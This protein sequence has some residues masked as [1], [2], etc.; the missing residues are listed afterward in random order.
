MREDDLIDL[1]AASFETKGPPQGNQF[2]ADLTEYDG[3]R[4]LTDC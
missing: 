2:D 1:G 4:Q 3:S